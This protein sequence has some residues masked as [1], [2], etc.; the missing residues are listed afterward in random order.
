MC[1]MRVVKKHQVVNVLIGI[2]WHHEVSIIDGLSPP[3]YG[4]MDS[5]DT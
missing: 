2:D 4:F 5:G 1:E 3:P